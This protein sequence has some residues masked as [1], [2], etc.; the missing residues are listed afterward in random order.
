MSHTILLHA[1]DAIGLLL[2]AAV[3]SGAQEPHERQPAQRANETPMVNL[4]SLPRLSLPHL[5]LPWA[6]QEVQQLPPPIP[7][8]VAAV[9]SP[10]VLGAGAAVV[11]EP[12]PVAALPAEAASASQGDADQVEDDAPTEAIERQEEQPDNLPDAFPSQCGQAEKGKFWTYEHG[13]RVRAIPNVEACCDRCNAAPLCLSWT[14]VETGALKEGQPECWLKSGAR[15]EEG[16]RPGLA[17]GI[18]SGRPQ[19]RHPGSTPYKFN[20]QAIHTPNLFN[21]Q[22]GELPEPP[23]PATAGGGEVRVLT[24][25]LFW[26][27]LFDRSCSGELHCYKEHPEGNGATELLKEQG[28]VYD[29]MAFQEC[30]DLE[31]VMEAAGMADEYTVFDGEQEI[32]MAYK[33]AKWSLESRGQDSVAEDGPSSYW[34]KRDVQFLRLRHQETGKVLLFMNHHGPLPISSGGVCGGR[35]TAYN[36]AAKVAAVAQPGDTV[37]ILGDFNSGKDSTTVRALSQKYRKVISGDK[38]G[39]IDH[40]FTNLDA[41]DVLGAQTLGGGGS[42]HDAV[43]ARL[44][45]R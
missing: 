26:W 19:P 31:Y 22:A 20:Y 12:S 25:N 23:R 17:S 1:V 9:G 4:F 24:Y 18:L 39:G 15:G 14:W 33:T 27:N 7:P 41:S 43:E 44:R 5:R 3:A 38:E 40:I 2:V 37:V 8:Q 10:E 13:I 35:T 28:P 6:R 21:C 34:R 29:V 16:G 45:L 36:I 32:C 42:D 30:M 11:T